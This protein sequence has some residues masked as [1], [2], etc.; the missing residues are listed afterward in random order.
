MTWQR[1]PQV[2]EEDDGTLK[3]VTFL[4]FSCLEVEDVLGLVV[5]PT[6][7]TGVVVDERCLGSRLA[8]GFTLED[9]GGVASFATATEGS[10]H[11]DSVW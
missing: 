4:V 3:A 5:R 7:D 6:E 1:S 11:D 8:V 9:V 10:F 2:C